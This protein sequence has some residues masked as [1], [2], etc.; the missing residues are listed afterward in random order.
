MSNV[1]RVESDGDA[2][3]DGRWELWFAI[4]S[5][6]AYLA[7]LLAEFGLGASGSLFVGLYLLAYFFGG[8]FTVRGAWQS[9]RRGRFEVD[10]LMIVAAVGAAAVG[11]LAEGAVLLFLFSIGHALEEF[12]MARATRSIEALAELAPRTATVRVGPDATEERPVEE[13]VV[14]DVVVVRPN[15]RVPA[16]GFV[17]VGSTAIDQSAVTGESMPVEK[18]PVP[19]VEKALANPAA[20]SSGS[21]VFAATVNGPGA[22]DM[23]VTAAAADTTLARVVTLVKEADTAQSPTQRFIDRFQRFYVPAVIAAVAVVFVVGVLFLQEPTVDSFYRAMLVLVAASPCALAIATPAAV[24]AGVARAARAGVLVKGGAPLET[25]GKVEAMAFDKTGTLTWGHPTVTDTIAAQGATTAELSAVAL[26]VETLSDHPLATAV[27]RDLA[28]LVP[29]DARLAA[30][31][32]EA[33]TGRGVRAVVDG[34]PT[35]MGSLRMLSEAGAEPPADLVGAVEQLQSEGRTTML[36]LHGERFLGVIG[37]MDAPKQEARDTLEALR[38]AGVGELVL[39][40]GDN[41][42]VAEAVGRSVGIDRALGELLPQDKVAAIRELGRESRI[43]C[44]VG[45]GVND[46]P[47]MANAS[48]GIAMGA[49]GSAVALETADI[50]LMADDLG[51]V[52]FMLRLSRATT[53]LIRQNLIAALA[54]VAF[55]VPA[56]LLGLAMGPIVFIHEG[57][58]VLVVLNALRLLRFDNNR[59]HHGI[60]HENKPSRQPGD[61]P[62]PRV[63]L[64]GRP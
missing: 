5:G 51:R 12:A 21:R 54:I 31:D 39:I 58:T 48:V 8:F 4:A 46:A 56:S 41:Q 40:S 13:L 53:R 17:S 24:L 49:A 59:D 55:L 50:A 16:D 20:I 47:A 61:A 42:Q 63:K 9:V 14:G 15:S 7:G 6:V 11:K 18:A 22:F 28:G 30:A 64:T 44:M 52:P 37:V 45:D 34:R 10:F 32:L 33:V 29:D 1:D 3:R 43:T 26:A 19:S 2:H 60:V 35:V 62:A 57:S 25:L 27:V 23:V 36:V 38:T